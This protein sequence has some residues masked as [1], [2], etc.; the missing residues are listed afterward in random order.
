MLA[1]GGNISP[2][3]VNLIAPLVIVLKPTIF[4]DTYTRG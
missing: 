3:A 4:D 1:N 2:G